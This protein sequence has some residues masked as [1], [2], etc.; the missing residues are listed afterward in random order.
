MNQENNSQKETI[1]EWGFKEFNDSG[2][3]RNWYV[4]SVLVVAALLVFSFFSANILF[5]LLVIISYLLILLFHRSQNEV[6]F[7]ITQDGIAVNQR[8]YP[9]EDIKNFYIIYNPPEVKTL[10]FEPKSPVNPRIPV[11]LHD[12]NPVAIRDWLLKFVDENLD[13]EFEPVSDQISRLLKL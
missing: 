11:P 2:R 10:Y 7:R 3:S 9:Y 6:S 1:F 8:F 13:R 12:Q 4:Y 5:G